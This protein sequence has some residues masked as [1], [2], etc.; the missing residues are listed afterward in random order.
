[1]PLSQHIPAVAGLVVTMA[2]SIA[3]DGIIERILPADTKNL[4][5][6]GVKMGLGLA[7]AALGGLIAKQVITNLTSVVET[8]VPAPESEPEETSEQEQN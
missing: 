3:T 4:T 5:A 2:A 1:M 8:M 7:G 6:F